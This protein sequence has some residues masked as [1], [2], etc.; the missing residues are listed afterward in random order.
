M[1]FLYSRSLIFFAFCFLMMLSGKAGLSQVSQVYRQEAIK[2]I[3]AGNFTGALEVLGMAIVREPLNAENFYLRGY[4]KYALDDYLGAEMDY[5]RSIDLSPYSADVFAQRAIVRTQME[6]YGGAMEDFARALEMDPGNGEIWFHRARANIIQKKTYSCIVDCNKALELN[7]RNESVYMLKAGAE[8]EIK[9]YDEAM[10]N[11]NAALKL[12]PESSNV[13]SRRGMLNVEMKRMDSAIRDF[14]EAIR[15]DSTNALAIFNRALAWLQLENDPAAL[16]DLSTVIRLSPYNSYAWYNRAILLIGIKDYYGAIRDFE[17]V[18]RLDPRNIISH[19]YRSKLKTEVKDYEGALADLDKTIDLLP[20]YTEAW[21]D[22][23]ELKMKMNDKAG[24]RD[25]YNQAMA[26]SK[27]NH[28]NPDSLKSDRLNDLKD[29]TKLSGDF[30]Q[31]NAMSAK[32]QNQAVDI[33]LLPQY[34]LLLW[35]AGFDRIRLYDVYQRPHYP[36]SILALTN[37]PGVIS[38][39]ILMEATALPA[40]FNDSPEPPDSALFRRAIALHHLRKYELAIR[41]LD[42]LIVTDSVDVTLWFSRACSRYELIHQIMLQEEMQRE[43]PASELTQKPAPVATSA[44]VEHT[45]EMVLADYDRALK[46]D[47]GFA[48]GWYN[49]GFINATMGNYREALDDFSKAVTMQ[50]NLAE[51]W[52][53]RGLIGILLQEN[54]NG[55]KDLSRAGELGIKDAY[56][57]MK[58]YCYKGQ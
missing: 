33:R 27:K 6:N 26:L 21:Y 9:R 51:A 50:D 29:L 15:L 31:M 55:C 11:L 35:K 46:L 41:D 8:T 54:H 32:F 7:F 30:E 25:D 43:F 39:S 52:Y 13:Y 5:T 47:P 42:Q 4:T 28:L 49:R 57:V 24:A 14:D 16:Q 3:Q 1:P 2:A 34:S 36:F 20:E 45:Y 48:F 40:I 18:S 56:R 44:G 10:E 19:F 17:M 37:Q 53:N 22:R 12:S 58:R 38:D 23:Y